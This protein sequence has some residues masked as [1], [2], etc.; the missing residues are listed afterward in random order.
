MELL[1]YPPMHAKQAIPNT[2]P[3]LT[4][5]MGPEAPWSCW[6]RTSAAWSNIDVVPVGAMMSSACVRE[7]EIALNG[8]SAAISL[9][10]EDLDLPSCTQLAHCR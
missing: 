2:F 4:M 7:R 6:R 10:E 9:D 1:T 5:A 8:E 3:F